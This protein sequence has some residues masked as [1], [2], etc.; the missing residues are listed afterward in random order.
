[1]RSGLRGLNL[2]PA[3][4]SVL[5]RTS[6]F[7]S[8]LLVQ[9]RTTGLVAIRLAD[10]D[11]VEDWRHARADGDV[12]PSEPVGPSARFGGADPADLVGLEDLRVVRHGG[13]EG[14][15]SARCV[16][17]YRRLCSLALEKP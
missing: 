10:R 1:M 7:E 3:A 12:V 13:E 8:L 15:S 9:D 14:R 5:D 16:G 4:G 17:M 2:L 6:I 11:A